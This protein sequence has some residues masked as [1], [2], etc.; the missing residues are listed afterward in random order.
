MNKELKPCPFCGGKA[1]LHA[2]TE[3]AYVKCAD[4]ECRSKIIYP[5][6]E[7]CAKDLAVEIWNWRVE[8]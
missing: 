3:F 6:A 7:F 8:K 5:N 2:C 4:C 1:E